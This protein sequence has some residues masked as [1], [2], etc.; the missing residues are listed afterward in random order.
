LSL[1][2]PQIYES[3]DC[4]YSFCCVPDGLCGCVEVV[5]M[6]RGSMKKYQLRVE[7]PNCGLVKGGS[8][9]RLTEGL[10]VSSYLTKER[11]GMR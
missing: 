8:I 3:L 2:F 4:Q 1:V 5:E 7:V 6:K 10:R 11:L 9:A